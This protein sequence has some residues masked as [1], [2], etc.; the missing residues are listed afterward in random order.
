MLGGVTN[1]IANVGNLS[2]IG[3]DINHDGVVNLIDLSVMLSHF[4]ANSTS[5]NWYPASD[6]NSDTVINSIDFSLMVTD[7]KNNGV[8]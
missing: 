6:L 8:I 2:C 1:Y 5:T 3:G 7:L 4:N